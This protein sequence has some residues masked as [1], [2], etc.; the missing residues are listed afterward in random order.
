M[1]GPYDYTINIPQPPAQNFLQSLLGIQQ[2]KGLQQQSEIAAQ[3][4]AFQ[5]QMQ[6]L[7]MEKARAAIDAQRASIAHSGAATNLLGVQTTAAKLGLAD[8]QLISSTLQNYFKDETKTIKD[9]APILPLL[10]A[11]AVEN[12]GKAEQIRV[13][14]EVTTRLNEGKEIT[15]S[16]IRGWSNRQTLLKGPEQ[17]QFQQSF[18]AMTPQFQ[19]AAKSGMINAVNAAFAGNMEV[20]RNS[21]A[22]VQQALLNSKDTS[23]AAK[24]VADSFGKIVN[25][26]DQN[27]NIPKEIL[28]LNAVNAANLVG[29][30]RLAE[31][32]LKVVKE[33]GDVT[34][35][36]GAAKGKEVDEEKRALDLEKERLQI[37]ELQQKL[38]AGRTEKVKIYASQ[39]KEGYKLNEEA[40]NATL[41]AE[42][43]R[44]IL[45]SIDSG[46]VQLPKS[47]GASVMQW[48]RDKVPFLSNDI[49]F[50]RTQYQALLAPEAKKNLPP[51]SASDADMR[52]AREGLLNKNATPK[53]FRKAVEIIAKLSEDQ[54]KYAEARLGWISENEGSIGTAVKDISV[55]GMPVKKGTPLNT[56]WNKVGKDLD[57]NKLPTESAPTPD[58]QSILNKYR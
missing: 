27:P 31:D 33:F 58:I 13:N 51:G 7:E 5:Q 25:L 4:A 20:A 50:L 17:Q 34:K 18:L 57:L 36:A 52:A 9:L 30:P 42:K 11:T 10:D 56:W 40:R 39:N 49:S 8:K 28:A 32:A 1:A 16:D 26:I 2:L 43:A 44:G 19:A 53:Q 37:Q 21:A 41:Q 23:P 29:D 15:A 6:P 55:F 54:A 3:Q 12:I 14:N 47:P 24:A 46:E 38:D 45:S 22:E 35:P 48:V